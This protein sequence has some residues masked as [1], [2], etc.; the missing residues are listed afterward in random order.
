MAAGINQ[1]ARD[2]VERT[3]EILK[4][5]G[6][7]ERHFNQLEHQYRLLASTWLLGVFVATGFVLSSELSVLF[8]TEW[9]IT[10]IGVLG[11][12][13]ITLIWNLDLMVYHQLL[14]AHFW[15]GVELEKR[16]ELEKH[17]HSWLPQIRND[18]LRMV[19]NRGVLPRAL[20]F[21]VGSIIAVLLLGGFFLATWVYIQYGASL[22]F[23]ATIIICLLV[24]GI[25]GGVIRSKTLAEHKKT[26]AEHKKTV[27]EH[28]KHLREEGGVHS[29]IN[30][31]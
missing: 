19:N 12:V 9:L 16:V 25:W 23:I 24:I 27:A 13:G 14:N 5:I 3:W 6:E 4:E 20:W 29:D 7:F 15:A 18:M 26:V 21:Y 28:L 22:R 17:N 30:N 8:P 31:H 11:A 1:D 10:A 2:N